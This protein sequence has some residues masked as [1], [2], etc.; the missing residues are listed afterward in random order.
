MPDRLYGLLLVRRNDDACEGSNK[1]HE[2][3]NR[4]GKAY[5]MLKKTVGSCKN[6]IISMQ[7]RYEWVG[8]ST[9]ESI[10]LFW[11]VTTRALRRQAHCQA[12]G[13]RLKSLQCTLLPPLNFSS[14]DSSFCI[15]YVL[16]HENIRSFHLF[17]TTKES[18]RRSNHGTI[19][20]LSL[21]FSISQE[22]QEPQHLKRAHN[23]FPSIFYSGAQNRQYQA[24][25][26]YGIRYQ[27]VFRGLNFVNR[28]HTNR[29]D[30]YIDAHKTLPL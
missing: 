21:E 2:A 8:I 20:D 4:N 17:L 16:L 22:P 3:D 6:W 28:G 19:R 10:A 29:S 30:A 11:N 27:K 18:T 25:I 23:I 7:D 15:C 13:R 24:S 14:T 12:S 5:T 1:H 9:R 26:S